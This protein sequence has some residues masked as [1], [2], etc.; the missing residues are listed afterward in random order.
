MSIGFTI[1]VVMLCHGPV[2][3]ARSIGMIVV[4]FALMGLLN[5]FFAYF[6]TFSI[7]C[8]MVR[9]DKH[10]WVDKHADAEKGAARKPDKALCEGS[11]TNSSLTIGLDSS[12][13]S[14][15]T[16]EPTPQHAPNPHAQTDTP[17]LRTHLQLW[18]LRNPILL[19]CWLLTFT[20]GLPLRY[21]AGNDVPLATLLLFS[22]WL[23]TLA[24]QAAIKSTPARLPAWLGTVL[25]GVLNPVLWTSLAMVAYVFADAAL[26]GRSL[27]AMLATLQTHT[28][29]STLILQTTVTTTTNPNATTPTPTPT[30]AAGDVAITL[31]NAG[32]VAWGLKLYA[33]RGRVVSRAG[34][35]CCGVSAGLALGNA[36]L[37]PALAGRRWGLGVGPEGAA[38][39][40]AAR[41][42][43]VALAG[44]VMGLLGG[45]V[46]LNAAMVVGGGIVY[47]MGLGLGVGRWLER[48]G[49]G[50]GVETQTQTQTGG[51][52]D[53][54]ERAAV[55]TRRRPND[56]RVVA[57][58]VTVGINAAAMGT[59]YLYEAQSESAPYAALSMIALGVMTVVFS[60]IPPLAGWI[61][62][63]VA[64]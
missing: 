28:P 8:L 64:E 46:G 42:V 63:S 61:V 38:L 9:Y 30:P 23:T 5:T 53:R 50:T 47:Q 49:T 4:C 21:R 29:L 17:S 14:S 45:D 60:S 40:F 22:S 33:H 16:D 37:G 51:G 1:P 19:L 6:L 55:T 26:S 24:I 56:P 31:L 18:A 58:G 20:I 11:P 43:T 48:T 13:E 25:A 54:E 15:E 7:Q 12:A 2:S 59:A 57:A 27:P 52:R 39:A 3:D 34:L 41:S 10:F 32:L 62:K 44:P 36:A 35:A